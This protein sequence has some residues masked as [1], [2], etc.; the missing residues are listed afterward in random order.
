MDFDASV[1][2]ILAELRGLRSETKDN[3]ERLARLETAMESVVGAGQPGRLTIIEDK[4]ES[5]NRW[6]YWSVGV[7]AG[8]GGAAGALAWMLGLVKH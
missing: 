5:L 6:R 8:V 2:L 3:G 1:S 7:G 4:I